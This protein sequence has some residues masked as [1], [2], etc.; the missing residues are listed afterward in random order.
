MER[1]E[2]DALI[3]SSKREIGAAILELQFLAHR[4]AEVLQRLS[5]AYQQVALGP[6]SYDFDSSADLGESGE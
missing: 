1:S 4:K 5:R 2:R 3:E 6:L